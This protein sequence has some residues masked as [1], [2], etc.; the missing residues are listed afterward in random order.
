[1]SWNIAGTPQK[2]VTPSSASANRRS[3]CSGS[4]DSMTTLVPPC[5]SAALPNRCSPATWK[6]G[7]TV[8]TTDPP[9][10]SPA[11]AELS[12]LARTER[13]VWTAPLGSPVVPEV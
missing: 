11:K 8:S 10:T 5:I 3:V 9:W 4:E 12:M 7:S 1:M 13:Y 2:W 6:V